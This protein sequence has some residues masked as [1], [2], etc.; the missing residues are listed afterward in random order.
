MKKSVAYLI[1]A[2]TIV[3]LATSCTRVNQGER[4][5]DT[6]AAARQVQTGTLGI[7][8]D[9]TLPTQA[10]YD[11]NELFTVVEIRNQGSHSVK[12]QECF[13]QMTGFDPNIIKGDY[14][15]A[16]SCAEGIGGPLEGKSLYNIQG[17]LNQV[18]FNSPDIKLPDGVFDYNPRLNI[19]TCYNYQTRATPSVCIDPLF[20]QVTSE[21][22]ACIPVDVSGGGGQGGPVGVSFIN[23]DM[24]GG[25]AIFEINIRNF[26]TGRV[27]DPLADI[28]QCGSGSFGTK[29]F[30]KVA[31]NVKLAGGVVQNCKPHNN[32]VRLFNGQGKIICSFDIAGTAAYETP[33]QVELSYGYVDSLQRQLRIIRTPN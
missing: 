28:R 13:V 8:I 24:V 27:L 20:Y 17:G 31:Y 15:K 14:S 32:F 16:R 2:L 4:P 7:T 21:Q 25:R 33:L 23:V 6:A 1:L 5:L 19:V 29:D 30:D 26:G 12:E 18:E 9:P 10:L 3:L 22:K 11:S